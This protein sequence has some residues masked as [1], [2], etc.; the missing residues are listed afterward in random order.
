MANID[1]SGQSDQEIE[2]AIDD[3]TYLKGSLCVP[4]GAR[5]IVLF[6]HGSGSSRFSPRNRYVAATFQQ[7]GLATLLMDLLTKEEELIDLETRQLR[8]DIELLS[9]R[10]VHATRWLLENK[11]TGN[12]KIAYF[13]SSTGASA[14]LSAA[15][16][17]NTIITAVVSRGGRP[18]L[19]GDKLTKVK[20]STLLIVG[21][22]DP[23]VIDINQDAMKELHAEKKLVIIPGATHLFEEPG[24]LEQVADLAAQ[25]FVRYLH[26]KNCSFK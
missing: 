15:A 1:I 21:G 8:F 22:N 24:T 12:L 6:A 16:D 13:G 25:W 20:A 26:D 17:L 5:G 9:K 3:K 18:D 4:R 11:E 2:I 19:A 10:V 23:I 7:M 14:A